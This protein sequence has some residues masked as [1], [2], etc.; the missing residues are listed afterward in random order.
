MNAQAPDNAELLIG[1]LSETLKHA[2]LP[3]RARQ[4]GLRLL[5]RVSRP[6]RIT[7]FGPKGSGKSSLLNMLIGWHLI[8]AG[9]DLPNL[10]LR[11]GP[12]WQMQ[13]VHQNGETEICNHLDLARAAAA[14]PSMIVIDAPVSLLEKISFTE[15]APGRDLAATRAAMAWALP[16]TD[17]ALWCANGFGD[18]DMALWSGVPEVL[19]DHAYLV[20]T[21]ADLL[22]RAGTL[23][24]LMSALA[25]VVS[26]EF[27]SFL[28]VASPQGLAA[29]KDGV[30]VKPDILRA[31]GGLGLIDT[32]RNHAAKGR[33]EDLDAA[34]AFLERYGS[35]PARTQAPAPERAPVAQPS[36]L[37]GTTS[38]LAPALHQAADR[39]AEL[40]SQLSAKGDSMEILQHC[41]ELAEDL[42][43][44]LYAVASAE[45]HEILEEVDQA[46]EMITLLQLE[47]GTSAA[48]DAVHL[49]AQL[50]SELEFAAAA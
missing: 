35:Q 8:P 26:E 33:Q 27:H 14:G 49:L 37:A 42:S 3:D 9:V 12:H 4:T 25:P 15:L 36:A 1:G 32:L 38:P 17:I 5:R 21:K 45:P 48:A 16:K 43:T 13:L 10:Q 20:L 18:T 23:P 7:L 11:H 39:I 2:S 44:E 19:K 6:V 22:A 31:S 40:G 30:L 24:Q 50:R 46:A 47:G 28:A 34:A 29:W 41:L